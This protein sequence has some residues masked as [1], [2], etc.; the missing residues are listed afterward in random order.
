MRFTTKLLHGAFSPDRATGSTTQPIYQTSAYYQETAAGME[1]VFAGQKPGFIY[2]RVGNPTVAGLERRIA[3]L[4]EG[5]GAVAFASGMAAVTAAVMNVVGAGDEIVS[6]SGLFG[7]TG[8]FFRE[9]ASFGVTVRYAAENTPAA[10]AALIT[11]KTKLIYVE[12][13]GNPKLDVA[14]IGA[15]ANV[16]HDAGLPLYVDSTVTT[17]YLV[18]PIPCGADVVIHSTSKAINGNGNSIGGIVVTG[19][20]FSWD[21]A[22]FPKLGE[23]S[24][25]RSM[26]YLA[27]LRARMVSDFGGCM[28][29]FNAYLTGMGL[30]TLALRVER[31]SANALALAKFCDAKPGVTVNYPGLDTSPYRALA[32]AQ[33]HDRYG[34]MLTLRLGTKE[35]AFRFIDSLRYALNVSNIGD[36]RTLVVHP[37]STIYCRMSD[38]EKK[39]AGVT[40]DL[41]RVNAGIEDIEDLTEDFEKAFAAISK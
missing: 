3:L 32:K 29:P 17:P 38:E 31:A 18:R 21:A 12:T 10:F 35:K 20:R 30:D 37:D 8:E 4:E 28:A 13:I 40:D 16:A 27:R 7:G 9:L 1:K 23:F 41:V 19:G 34:M 15:L 26:S 36:A 33:F 14:D 22:R 5:V 25:F 11:E 39:S 2:T 6:G 24:E